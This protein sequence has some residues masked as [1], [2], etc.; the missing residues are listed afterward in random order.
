[1]GAAQQSIPSLAVGGSEPPNHGGRRT[2]N[3]SRFG[4]HMVNS[5]DQ[6]SPWFLK[7]WVLAV[8]GL[9]VA[10]NHVRAGNVEP[11]HVEPGNVDP[12]HAIP[13]FP[14]PTTSYRP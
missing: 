4:E 7:P 9:M 8:W 6:S 10:A 11:G 3:E 14:G 2:D 5:D 1:V 12:G 13:I